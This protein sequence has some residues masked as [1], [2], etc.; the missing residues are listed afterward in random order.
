MNN[1][2]RK[3]LSEQK[4]KIEEAYKYIAKAS[5]ILNEVQDEINNVK[6][7]E[8]EKIDNAT[9]GLLA[10]QKYQDIQ[11]NIDTLDELESSISDVI[12]SIDVETL[13]DHEAFDV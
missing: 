4:E 1:G 5:E 11:S 13:T 12:D 8:E 3:I 2:Q 9:E 6:C 10:T 7:Q